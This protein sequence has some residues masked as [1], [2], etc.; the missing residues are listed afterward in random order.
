[1]FQLLLSLNITTECRALAETCTSTHVGLST[2]SSSCE[3]GFKVSSN[4]NCFLESHSI[5]RETVEQLIWSNAEGNQDLNMSF[6]TVG[7]SLISGPTIQFSM[8]HATRV[9]LFKEQFH[10]V[11][12]F[13]FYLSE[14]MIIY[15]GVMS[16]MRVII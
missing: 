6:Q 5:V 2:N 3:G 1:M 8:R 4:R 16:Y 7:Y 10:I 13:L 11:F 9:F 12:P 14:L 15:S